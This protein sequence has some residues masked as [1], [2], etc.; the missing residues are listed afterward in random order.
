MQY[1]RDEPALNNNG[2]IVDFPAN[3]NH[4]ASFKFEIKIAS[5]I[6]NHDRQN[7]KTMVPLKYLKPDSHLPKNFVLFAWFKVLINRFDKWPKSQ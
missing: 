7:I 6:G 4:S 3:N 1:Y 5:R 2:A